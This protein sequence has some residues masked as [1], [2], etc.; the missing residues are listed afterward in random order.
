[1]TESFCDAPQQTRDIFKWSDAEIMLADPPTGQADPNIGQQQ[2]E[3][4]P[5]D[6]VIRRRRSHCSVEQSFR[7]HGLFAEWTL[8]LQCSI[9]PPGLRKLRQSMLKSSWIHAIA[10]HQGEGDTCV[11]CI[12]FDHP[13][14]PNHGCDDVLACRT[15]HVFIVTDRATL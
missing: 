3:L 7:D 14:Q 10:L 6:S 2:V 8:W 13:N 1:M 4:Q 5:V 9:G 15:V 12:G 11:Q